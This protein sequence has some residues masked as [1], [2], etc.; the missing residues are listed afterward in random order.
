MYM[1]V[2][3][4]TYV[5]KHTLQ[6]HVTLTPPGLPRVCASVKRGLYSVKRGLYS[7]KRELQDQ[8]DE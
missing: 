3:V 2:C 4:H 7:V 1:C 6:S 5:S 8:Q